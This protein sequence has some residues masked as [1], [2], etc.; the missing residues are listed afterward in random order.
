M[1]LSIHYIHKISLQ[2]EKGKTISTL[3]KNYIMTPKTAVEIRRCCQCDQ[4][5]HTKILFR[6][7]AYMVNS[8]RIFGLSIR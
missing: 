6:V 5:T 4:Q 8:A 3:A 1:T 2:Q 7:N